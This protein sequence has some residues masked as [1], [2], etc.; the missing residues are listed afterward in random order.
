MQQPQYVIVARLQS[1]S[2]GVRHVFHSLADDEATALTDA[3]TQLAARLGQRPEATPADAEHYRLE[4]EGVLYGPRPLGLPVPLDLY[5]AQ[6]IRAG[7]WLRESRFDSFRAGYEYASAKTQ[8]LPGLTKITAE[9][10]YYV[11]ALIQRGIEQHWTDVD[12]IK[13]GLN[14]GSKGFAEGLC[15][16]E[17]D[18]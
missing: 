14:R 9:E 12:R 4:V 10:A 3:R 13:A 5:L 6:G 17:G 8:A 11:H 2:G 7:S 15:D 18:R 16:N 1:P